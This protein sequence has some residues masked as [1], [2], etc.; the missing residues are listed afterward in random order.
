MRNN[1]LEMDIL[2]CKSKAEEDVG[3]FAKLETRLEEL[4]QEL[5]TSLGANQELEEAAAAMRS[6]IENR[7]LAL[8]DSM[9]R[10]SGQEQALAELKQKLQLRIQAEAE[11]KAELATLA[12]QHG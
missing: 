8:A 1:D 4:N 12:G 3:R 2:Q 6:T 5:S 11:V 9:E 10:C 7:D